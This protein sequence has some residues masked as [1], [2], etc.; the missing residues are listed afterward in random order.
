MGTLNCFQHLGDML[1]PLRMGSAGQIER[2]RQSETECHYPSKGLDEKLRTN[3]YPSCDTSSDTDYRT[4]NM[5]NLG[6]AKI[7]AMGQSG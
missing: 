5:Q 2:K 7:R 6:S 4:K 1:L 3:Q